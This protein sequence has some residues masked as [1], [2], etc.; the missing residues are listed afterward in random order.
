M[1]AM[2]T[3]DDKYYRHGVSVCHR[4]IIP[5]HPGTILLYDTI[6]N[7]S[8]NNNQLNRQKYYADSGKN[9]MFRVIL[10]TIDRVLL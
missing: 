4:N 1:G 10:K 3:N 8:N 6:H 9:I 5:S 7:Q 2:Q